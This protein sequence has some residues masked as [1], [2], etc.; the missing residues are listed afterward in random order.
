MNGTTT[1][2]C[3]V[4]VKTS[5]PVDARVGGFA[6]TIIVS[7]FKLSLFS[8][9]LLFLFSGGKKFDLACFMRGERQRCQHRNTRDKM[10]L[11]GFCV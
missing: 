2:N 5:A 10:K 11:H 8:F 6:A 4:V 7:S 9:S 3:M 1:W